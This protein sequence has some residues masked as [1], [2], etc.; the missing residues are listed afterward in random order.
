MRT[1]PAAEPRQRRVTV[2][3]PISAIRIVGRRTRN[4]RSSPRAA[5]RG[6]GAGTA[7]A[8]RARSPPRPQPLR[9]VVEAVDRLAAADEPPEEP[10]APHEERAGEHDERRQAQSRCDRRA[11]DTVAWAGTSSPLR[12]LPDLR[13]DRGQDLVQIADHGVVGAREDRCL[14][15]GVDGEHP[16]CAAA[17]GDVLRG[18]ADPARRESGEIFV[19]V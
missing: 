19:P 3:A 5:P 18:A 11:Q 7:S 1:S 16:L 6:R 17:A 13:R 4:P 14:R 2:T 10:R 15:I 8:G 9:Q 12:R